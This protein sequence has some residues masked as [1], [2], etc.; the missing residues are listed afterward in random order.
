MM[1]CHCLLFICHSIIY[2][3]SLRA[4]G[5]GMLAATMFMSL[6]GIYTSRK[7]IRLLRLSDNEKLI[8]RCTAH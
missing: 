8:N 4:E 5:Y 6:V 2:V 3:Y 7:D 1:A